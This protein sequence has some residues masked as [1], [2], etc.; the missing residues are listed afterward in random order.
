[1]KKKDSL[2]SGIGNYKEIIKYYDNWSNQYEYTL[3]KWNYRVPQK[4]SFF[5]KKILTVKPSNLLDLAC[6]TGLFGLEI[7]KI[8]PYIKIDGSDIS[9]KIIEE[10]RLKN[11]YDNLI[12][13]NFDKM[14]PEK[15]KYDLISCIGAL[16]YTRDPKKLFLKIQKMTSSSGH[17]IFTHRY[18]LWKKQDYESMLNLLKKKWTIKFISNPLLYLPRNKNFL[19]NIKVKIVILKKVNY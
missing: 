19:N 8:F 4:A 2:V 3:K 18:D 5:L 15:K 14:P 17:F 16:T 7:K 6:G 9:K 12:I 10:A 13:C 1:M 11:I